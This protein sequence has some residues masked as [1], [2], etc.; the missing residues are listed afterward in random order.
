MRT[1]FS[2]VALSLLAL[3]F[4]TSAAADDQVDY[5]GWNV[6]IGGGAILFEQDEELE[7]THLYGVT[8]GYDFDNRWT[9]EG[10]ISYLPYVK[11][12]LRDFIPAYPA[13]GFRV[14]GGSTWSLRLTADLLYHLVSNPASSFD[15]FVGLTAGAAYYGDKMENDQNWDPFYGVGAGMTYWL[16]NGLGIRGDYKFVVAGHDTELNHLFLLSLTYSWGRRAKAIAAGAES[17]SLSMGEAN[18]NLKPI[19]FAFDSSSLSAQAKQVLKENADYLSANPGTK[20]VLEGHCDERGTEE[21]NLALGERRSRSA[22]DYLRSLG[23]SPDRMSTVSYGESR[24]ADLGK[25][26]AAYARNRRVE[27]VELPR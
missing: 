6:G 10:G 15:P 18:P 16:T 1:L 7:P 20:V 22:F 26:E 24:P 2:H 11:A 4:A 13:S 17:D 14:D 12:N 27:C 23:V 3:G 5:S 9:L 19:Y 21:Y 25:N 8:V